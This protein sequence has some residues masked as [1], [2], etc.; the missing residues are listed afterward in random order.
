MNHLNSQRTPDRVTVFS[1]TQHTNL[2]NSDSPERWEAK[3]ITIHTVP[4]I[5]QL[6]IK[7]SASHTPIARIHLR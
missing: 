3:D 6:D 1:D 4:A 5:N 2:N 7:L